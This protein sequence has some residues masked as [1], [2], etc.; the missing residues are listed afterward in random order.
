MYLWY[1]RSGVSVAMVNRGMIQRWELCNR[2]QLT[3]PKICVGKL[4]QN[5]YGIVFWK[6]TRRF[7]KIGIG[8]RNVLET[9]DLIRIG[10]EKMRCFYWFGPWNQ[11]KF[12][13]N[14]SLKHSDDAEFF[15]R[16]NEGNQPFRKIS[17]KYAIIRIMQIWNKRMLSYVLPYS[18]AD[19]LYVIS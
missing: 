15:Y 13:N 6:M 12:S 4:V 7:S 18:L 11:F 8:I 10:W 16:K 2:S 5:W 19:R 3:L 1:D 9:T 14:S 17:S